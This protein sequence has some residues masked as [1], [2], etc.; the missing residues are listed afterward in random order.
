M[1]IKHYELVAEANTFL[2]D[3]YELKLEVPIVFNT[4]LKRALGRMVF[5]KSMNGN[6]PIKIEM[7][8]DFI[9]NH[10]KDHIIDVLKHEL[11]HYALCVLKKPFSDGD[12]Y[13]E[14]ELKRL[15]VSRTKTYKYLGQLHLYI[16]KNCGGKFERKR[17]LNEHARCNCS[18]G[19]NLEY[20]GIINKTEEK[21]ETVQT[22]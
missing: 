20:K 16:C 6:K 3:N 13:F 19:P 12:F 1:N 4:R 14:K 10:P 17:K 22:G 2:Q 11:V 18:V 21:D 15:G 8:T 7:S 9:M 5:N